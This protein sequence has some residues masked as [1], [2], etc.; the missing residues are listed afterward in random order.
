MSDQFV[1]AAKANQ[2]ALERLFTG[3]PGIRTY[4]D[5]EL[6]RDAD[7]R[8]REQIALQ[9]TEQKLQLISLQ[10]RLLQVKGLP[11]VD[12]VNRL[13]QRLQTLADRVRSASYGYAGLFDAVKIR[14]EQLA[15]LHRFDVGLAAQIGALAD[16]VTTAT[17]AL[18]DEAALAA[19]LTKVETMIATLTTY[20]S[21]RQAAVTTPDQ[22]TA[23]AVPTLDP[24]LDERIAAHLAV[25]S[26]TAGEP[27]TE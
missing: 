2:G 20:F 17:T 18:P 8:L 12:S 10:Q 14:E 19:A 1:E 25:T 16:T 6:R 23:A 22:L 4:A 21:Q 7:K 26:P 13:V 5:K 3:L 24:A 9:L 11:Q 15:A 27:S